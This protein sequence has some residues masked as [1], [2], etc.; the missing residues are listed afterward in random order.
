MTGRG[1]F[2][3]CMRRPDPITGPATHPKRG[4]RR[5]GQSLKAASHAACR[6]FKPTVLV[7][8]QGVFYHLTIIF[9][10]TSDARPC[11]LVNGARIQSLTHNESCCDRCRVDKYPC[12]FGAM[13]PASSKLPSHE[14][15]ETSLEHESTASMKAVGNSMGD[16][17][18][19]VTE[20]EYPVSM[21]MTLQSEYPA[22]GDNTTSEQPSARMMTPITDTSDDAREYRYATMLSLMTKKSTERPTGSEQP[23]K[24]ISGTNP[25][26]ALLGKDLK[27][28]IV[29]NSC[30]FRTPDPIGHAAVTV[31]R[32]GSDLQSCDWEGYYRSRGIS[33]ARLRFMQEVGCF[34]IPH[35]AQRSQLLEIYFKHIHPVLPVIDRRDFLSLYYGSDNPPPLILLQ[36]VFLAAS[37]YMTSDSGT[38]NGIPEIRSYC[39]KL[40]TKVRALIDAEI[41]HERLAVIQASLIA[42]L[43]WEGREGLNSALD[44]LS[45]AVRAGQEMGLHRKKGPTPQSKNPEKERLHQRIWWC[46]YTL[47]RMCAA[48]EGTPFLINETDCDVELLTRED[49]VG[50]DRVTSEVVLINLSMARVIEDTVRPLYQ[51]PEDFMLLSPSGVSVR[52]R[53]LT[54]LDAIDDRIRLTLLSGL[55][56][57]KALQTGTDPLSVSFGA[58]LLTQYVNLT[59]APSMLSHIN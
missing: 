34:D 6:L 52:Q 42:S 57:S 50:E 47:D 24:L 29:T 35:A 40:H 31:T 26:S 49:L 32:T 59:E 5:I 56:A 3:F 13:E 44:S 7:S 10:S 8:P 45:L 11:E 46:T 1:E 14:A 23:V 18:K 36:A 33:A 43:H 58:F 12:S 19:L 38:V 54:Q 27:H 41:I 55:Q 15:S 51:P 48:Q 17:P 25:L 22:P 39:D 30:S 2:N 20:M 28:T 4:G 16:F 9:V 21:D 37:R 53:L